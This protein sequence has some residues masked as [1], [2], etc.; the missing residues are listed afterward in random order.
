MFF[1]SA[2]T[3]LVLGCGAT[4]LAVSIPT[5]ITVMNNWFP[6]LIIGVGTVELILLCL[7][8]SFIKYLID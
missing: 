4:I 8:T 1:E 7:L 6:S 3:W 5:L 2:V